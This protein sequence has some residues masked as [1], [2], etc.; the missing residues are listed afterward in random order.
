MINLVRCVHL[1]SGRV[2]P[3][4]RCKF[5]L[6]FFSH[7]SGLKLKRHDHSSALINLRAYM[8]DTM[9]NEGDSLAP[10]SIHSQSIME[11]E[12]TQVP[13][14]PAATSQSASDIPKPSES[15]AAT[16]P[17]DPKSTPN[18]KYE[19]TGKLE[20]LASS[21][22]LNHKDS[23]LQS[24][25]NTI[26]EFHNNLQT[27]QQ[28]L[29]KET[30]I[31]G[32]EGKNE[33]ISTNETCQVDDCDKESLS[34]NTLP[35][36][37]EELANL[38]IV[39]ETNNKDEN[40][41]SKETASFEKTEFPVTQ[42]HN[43]VEN[44][45]SNDRLEETDKET[46]TAAT[47]NESPNLQTQKSVDTEIN[48]ILRD[49][50]NENATKVHKLIE[51]SATPHASTTTLTQQTEV[52]PNSL[53]IH[54]MISVLSQSTGQ[55][56]NFPAM[57]NPPVSNDPN[58]GDESG[59]PQ[60]PKA[61]ESRNNHFR[62]PEST[63]NVPT[64]GVSTETNQ[65]SL[66]FQQSGL[67]LYN[68]NTHPSN[69]NIN[70]NSGHHMNHYA[71]SRNVSQQSLKRQESYLTFKAPE[72]LKKNFQISQNNESLS[73]NGNKTPEI[74]Q[75][76]ELKFPSERKHEPTQNNTN[77]LKNSLLSQQKQDQEGKEEA[78]N[79][80]DIDL[81]SYLSAQEPEIDSR[82]QQK[83]WLQR[84]NV[85]TLND[86]EDTQHAPTVIIN[87]STRFQYEQHSRE[88]LHIRRFVN[89][90]LDSLNRIQDSGVT[91]RRLSIEK[92][93]EASSMLAKSLRD[94]SGKSKMQSASLAKSI[95]L[96]KENKVPEVVFENDLTDYKDIIKSMWNKNCDEFKGEKS[97][98]S[99][100]SNSSSTS[101]NIT[102]Q[103]QINQARP[104]TNG[105][106]PQYNYPN[107]TAFARGNNTSF[108]HANTQTHHTTSL[109]R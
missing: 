69:S 86:S 101:S 34:T 60:E 99:H 75:S 23:K 95:G 45:K 28:N 85:A 43:V 22:D 30:K 83:L 74:P 31:I 88:F 20:S 100:M 106:S 18:L 67:T 12:E 73:G 71:L 4:I 39:D 78:R 42:N 56:E 26:S 36:L 6:I 25:T 57:K 41:R 5:M 1:V 35:K 66:I 96:V 24:R 90:I 62:D 70:Q 102:Q 37:S 46:T 107:S 97:S 72:N 87:Q 108:G 15:I 61:Q 32:F 19:D 80:L 2:S 50:I 10:S 79:I 51:S 38:N 8:S 65:D 27:N 103:Y 77:T 11:S 44:F 64:S 55:E 47:I 16:T 76:Q 3:N 13:Y 53:N 104:Q 91:K 98:P 54:K 58:F 49:K 81:S 63:T 14:N 109:R 7:R 21:I 68:L 82:T 40:Q 59:L 105:S 94:T 52:P 9:N 93:T 89:P 92:T 84:E 17:I 29:K 48:D 33:V